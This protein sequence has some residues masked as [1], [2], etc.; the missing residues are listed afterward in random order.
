MQK[1]QRYGATEFSAII[2]VAL[3]DKKAS[4]GSVGEVI[5]GVDLKLSEGDDGKF[6]LR[7]R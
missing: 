3:D 2:A 1:A 4:D 7:V 5:P 6:L